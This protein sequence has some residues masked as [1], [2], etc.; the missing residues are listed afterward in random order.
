MVQIGKSIHDRTL[1][2]LF[3]L[4]MSTAITISFKPKQVTKQ[5]LA[6]LPK[7][8]QDVITKRYGLGTETKKMTLESIG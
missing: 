2:V 8:A 6:S 7:R 5:L 4:I 3:I 1:F